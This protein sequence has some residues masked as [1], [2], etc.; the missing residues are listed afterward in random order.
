M[1]GSTDLLE[2]QGKEVRDQS[3]TKCLLHD[4]EEN[5]NEQSVMP[6]V[7]RSVIARHSA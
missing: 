7:L 5:E 4:A 1:V 3:V 2:D 6:S